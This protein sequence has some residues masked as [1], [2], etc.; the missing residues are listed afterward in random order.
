MNIA[1]LVENGE[2]LFKKRNYEGAVAIFMQAVHLAPNNRKAREGLRNA[3]LKQREGSYPNPFAVMIFGLPAKIGMFF[4][5][6]SKKSNPEAYMEAC[7]KFLSIDPKNKRV[8]MALGDAAYGAGHL[9][10]AVVA[11]QTAADHN[12]NDVTA[13]KKLAALYNRTGELG[14]AHETYNRVVELDPKDQ[15]AIKARKNV[16]AEA[17]LR[18]TGFERAESSMDL[19]KDKHVLADLEA[20]ARIHQTADDL[21]AQRQKLEERLAAEPSNVDLLQDLAEVQKKQH[22][23]DAAVASM[24]KAA[25]LK[26]NDQTIAFERDDYLMERIEDAILTLKRD[27]KTDEAAEREK[28]LVQTQTSAFRKRV[29]AYPTNLQLRFKLG[30]LLFKQGEMDEAIGEFQQTVRDPKYKSESQLQLGR[31][32]GAKG[33]LDLAVSQL[34]QALEGL[35]GMNARVKEIYYA[36]G[37][38]H[39]KKGDLSEAKEAFGKIYEVDI[40]FQDVADRLNKL[41]ADPD[42]GKLSLD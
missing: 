19:V 41:D 13:L 35:S 28:E 21:G 27:G 2:N 33:Q 30:E 24:E 29:K 36:L 22:D 34:K 17:S 14:K 15:E 23:W 12:P 26:P 1:K 42:P 39:E 9:E 32:F 3:Q 10:A 18:D 4:S 37:D 38:V 6:L 16:A 31:A 25:Q 5:G 20:D 8:N 11:Y 40:G 7:E